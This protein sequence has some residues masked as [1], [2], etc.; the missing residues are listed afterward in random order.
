MLMV[1]TPG[2]QPSPT[3]SMRGSSAA[4][5]EICRRPGHMPRRGLR[6]SPPMQISHFHKE[7]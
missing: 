7:Q 4:Y 6:V 5:R 3:L 2:A 1:I